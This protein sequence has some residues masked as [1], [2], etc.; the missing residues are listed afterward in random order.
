M[1]Y[2]IAYALGLAVS[3]KFADEKTTALIKTVAEKISQEK[4]GC[5]K[6]GEFKTALHIGM[7]WTRKIEANY[8]HDTSMWF[9][10]Q[11]EKQYHE[12]WYQVTTEN[13]SDVDMAHRM[14]W[15]ID[16]VPANIWG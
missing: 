12:R 7:K 16:W 11:T 13:R 15:K 2:S 8:K 4:P 10:S 9:L 6:Y 5:K 14:G 3:C 1:A